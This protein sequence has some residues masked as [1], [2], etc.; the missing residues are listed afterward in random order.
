LSFFIIF[1]SDIPHF[2]SY[3][4]YSELSLSSMIS[5]KHEENAETYEMM[6]P[7][8][9]DLERH[10]IQDS[11]NLKL[12]PEYISFRIGSGN[13]RSLWSEYLAYFF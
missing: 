10:H 9:S 1:L 2:L 12:G 4:S 5:E 8:F 7:G 6:N 13:G 3:T 11:L